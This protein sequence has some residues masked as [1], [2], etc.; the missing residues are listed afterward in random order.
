M[1]EKGEI[2]CVNQMRGCL[3]LLGS[4]VS[5]NTK[6]VVK[7]GWARHSMQQEAWAVLISSFVSKSTVTVCDG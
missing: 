1:A 2:E 7:R 6:F 3:G 4:T 5:D